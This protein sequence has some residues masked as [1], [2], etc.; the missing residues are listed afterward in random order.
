MALDDDV[1]EMAQLPIFQELEPD[2]LRLIAFSAET[3]IL[4]MGDVLFTKGETSDGGFVVLSGSFA[5]ESGSGL[6]AEIVQAHS[7]I[8]EMALLTATER[9]AT[10]VAREPSTVLVIRRA[11]FH[12]VLKEYPQSALRMRNSIESRLANFSSGIKL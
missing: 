5:I 6:S 12:R 10:M 7:L 3:R 8:G 1:R 4:R 9:P 2:A 11:I